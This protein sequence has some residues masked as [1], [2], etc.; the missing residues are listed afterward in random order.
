MSP[1]S[2]FVCLLRSRVGF[3][4]SELRNKQLEA[5][6]PKKYVWLG[7]FWEIRPF[8]KLIFISSCF[9]FSYSLVLTR[10]SKYLPSTKCLRN[11][12]FLATNMTQSKHDQK[13][14]KMTYRN[15]NT[16]E[17]DQ[18]RWKLTGN[19]RKRQEIKKNK[20]G[21]NWPEPTNKKR[22][23]ILSEF[24]FKKWLRSMEMI[25]LDK[26]KLYQPT[27]VKTTERPN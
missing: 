26:N 13:R 8:F 9:L 5:F 20:F 25:D 16:T 1:F 17:S 11:M 27:F 21:K 4:W 18:I 23:K 14:P 2:E 15:S 22:T 7:F 19:D 24:D 3:R 10:I 12:A 6:P